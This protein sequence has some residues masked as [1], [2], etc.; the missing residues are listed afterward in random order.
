MVT[1]NLTNR[2]NQ[3]CI[4]CEIGQDIPSQRNDWITY[5]DMIWILDEMHLNRIPKISLCGG[6]PF[7]FKE[8]IKV[9]EYASHKGIRCS[10]TSNGMNLNHLTNDEWFILRTYQAEINISIDSF[11]EEI[12][13]FTRGVKQSLPNIITGLEKIQENGIPVTLLS[14]ISRYN[15]Q[16]ISDTFAKAYNLGIKQ[17]LFQPVIYYSN[18]PDRHPLNNKSNLNISTEELPHLLNQLT[19]ILQFERNH[20][21]KSNAYRIF[22]WIS[23]YIETASTQ[24][25]WFFEKV[26]N[27]FYCRE[28]DAIIDISYDGGIQPCGLAL[29]KINI[30]HHK[31]QRLLD[32]WRQSTENLRTDMVNGRYHQICNGCCH[33]F[34]R[35]MLASVIRYPFANRDA[36]AKLMPLLFARVIHESSKKIASVTHKESKK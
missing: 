36:L 7:L 2:C 14:V 35:N 26:L 24:E 34:S 12:E 22:H 32:L 21:I 27:K 25:G 19:K 16:N 3:R 1:V 11:E 20:A 8:I 4:Y 23:H 10:I 29:S 15:Y 13:S 9:V 31:D 30:K 5:D 6:E 28:I 18:Y 33:H 17:M